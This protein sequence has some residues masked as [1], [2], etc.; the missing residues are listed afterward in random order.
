MLKLQ[1]GLAHM[2]PSIKIPSLQIHP[3]RLNYGVNSILT[4]N[5]AFGSFPLQPLLGCVWYDSRVSKFRPVW[6][7]S[8]G[9]FWLI[10]CGVKT[11]THIRTHHTLTHV[12]VCCPKAHT[13]THTHTQAQVCTPTLTHTHVHGSPGSPHICLHIFDK[14]C[15]CSSSTFASHV[16][17]LWP[18]SQA[19]FVG[20]CLHSLPHCKSPVSMSRVWQEQ[21]TVSSVNSPQTHYN[22]AIIRSLSQTEGIPASSDTQLSCG[23]T[24][25]AENA[26][27]SEMEWPCVLSTQCR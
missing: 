16:V 18:L 5:R 8:M 14:V 26:M 7:E 6:L 1:P 17:D 23:L 4:G 25:H 15:S 11:H 9:V 2:T 22:T 27:G 10:F 21:N 3:A 13:R 20:H 24:P 19:V 12:L